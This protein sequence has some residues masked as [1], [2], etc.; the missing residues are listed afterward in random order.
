MP[1][2]KEFEI[3]PTPT[4][5][6]ACPGDSG[7]PIVCEGKYTILGCLWID[8]NLVMRNFQTLSFDLIS[9]NVIVCNINL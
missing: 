3:C 5:Q 7:G 6:S 2:L 9:S 1:F 4:E 8:M